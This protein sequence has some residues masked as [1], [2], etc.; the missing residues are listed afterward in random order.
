MGHSIARRIAC[1]TSWPGFAGRCPN[2]EAALF[3]GLVLGD[4][5]EQPPAMIDRFRAS[6]LSH[7]TA[8]S[9]QNVAFLLAAASPFLAAASAGGAVG[10]HRGADRLVRDAHPVRAVDHPRRGD[11]GALGD[12]LRA[13]PRTPSRTAAVHRRDR[14]PA[15]RPAARALRRLLVVDRC[16]RRRHDARPVACRSAAGCSDCSPHPCAIT[17]GAQAGVLVPALLVFGQCRSSACPP[18]CWQG[19]SPAA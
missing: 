19:R 17:L 15:R 5:A 16:H 6:G 8:V 10:D 7:L 11:G 9:G 18:T 13:R 3:R 1:A 12:R 2:G 4:D 14:D